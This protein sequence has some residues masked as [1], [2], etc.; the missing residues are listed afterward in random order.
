MKN[1]ATIGIDLAK[2]IFQIHGTDSKGKTVL[3][4][5]MKRANVLNFFANMKPC[6][7]GMEAC[8]GSHHWARELKKLGH[9]PKQMPPQYVKPY[10]KTNKN[11]RNDAEA[12]CEAVT[13]PNMH[14]VP[15]KTIEQQDIQAVHR[16]RERQVKN[17][18]AL[19][20]QARALLLEIGIAVPKGF[21]YLRTMLPELVGDNES[22]LT[23]RLRELIA[24]M[25]SEFV[26]IEAR[27]KNYNKELEKMSQESEAC[28]RLR[29]MPGFG[30]LSATAFVA[31]I[32][33]PH[34]FKNGRQVAAWLGLV[35]RQHSSG[36]NQRLGRISKRGNTY[37]R[38][39]L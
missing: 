27:I 4:K 2:N 28:R 26:D 15:M 12:I 14:F 5:R 31:S 20:N 8:G 32:G 39:L 21:R 18:T 22:G 19:S 17:R 6:V 13:R 36:N 33:D 30:P 10:V 35:P 3:V 23:P 9:Q 7:I 11:D 37:L 16:C 1:I 34:T 29:Q 38:T 24:D 25:Y